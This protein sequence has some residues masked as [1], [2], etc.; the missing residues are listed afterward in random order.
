MKISVVMPVYLGE[1]QF[2]VHKNASHPE[3]KFMRSV[4]SFLDQ[5]HEDKEL[6]IVSDGCDKAENIY[7]NEFSK[8]QQIVFIKIPKQSLYGGRTRQTGVE[9]A[10]GDVIC[11]LDHDDMIG[12]KHLLIINDNF[13][14]ANY[15][16]VYYNDHLVKSSDFRA[17]TIRDV[18][19]QRNSMGTSSIC[20]KANIPVVWGD[21]NTHDFDMIQQYLL[22]LR[23]IKITTPQYYVCH[24]SGL[25]MDF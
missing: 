25:K 14:T 19:P 8:E 1:Y 22:P 3:D 15:D 10:T 20:H 23:S 21:G 17:I 2:G 12:Q 4:S 9:M 24:C 16:W 5:I 13:D 11:Y 18:I 7:Y 6:I